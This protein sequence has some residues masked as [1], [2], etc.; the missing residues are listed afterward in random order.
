LEPKYSPLYKYFVSDTE[1]H[2]KPMDELQ[3]RFSRFLNLFL[4]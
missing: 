2:V 1:R 4:R 3:A